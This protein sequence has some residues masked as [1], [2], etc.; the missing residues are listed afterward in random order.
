MTHSA[1]HVAKLYALC[2]NYKFKFNFIA[3]KDRPEASHKE[4]V[5]LAGVPTHIIWSLCGD[6]CGVVGQQYLYLCV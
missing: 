6:C 5:K 2:N 4:T 3:K 1:L